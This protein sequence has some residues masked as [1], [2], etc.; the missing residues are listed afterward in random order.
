VGCKHI[1]RSF[2]E[3]IVGAVQSHDL[4]TKVVLAIS[5][6][7]FAVGEIYQTLFYREKRKMR[8]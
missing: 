4:K 3:R 2:P 8:S 5:L 1:A 7:V 6:I